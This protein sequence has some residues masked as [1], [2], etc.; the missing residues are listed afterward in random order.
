MLKFLLYGHQLLSLGVKFSL[1]LVEVAVK[2][3]NAFLQVSDLLFFGHQL[4]LVALNI[5][6]KNSLFTLSSPARCHRL[7]KAL[8]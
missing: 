8:Q 6:K 5:V 2:H 4:A 3:G 1:H 7:L